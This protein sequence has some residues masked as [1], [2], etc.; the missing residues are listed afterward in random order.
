[1]GL[2]LVRVLAVVMCLSVHLSITSQCSTETAKHRIPQTM[3]HDSSGI[4]IFWCQ[5]SQQNSIF[6]TQYSKQAT[7]AAGS[8]SI[9]KSKKLHGYNAV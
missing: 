3:P 2:L 9:D 5:K 7:D 1:M 4:L 8:E 6:R